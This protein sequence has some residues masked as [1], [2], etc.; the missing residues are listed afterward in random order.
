MVF[1]AA[2]ADCDFSGTKRNSVL[3]YDVEYSCFS[4]MKDI[5]YFWAQTLTDNKEI[6]TACIKNTTPLADNTIIRTLQ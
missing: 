3:A 5:K 4:K 6:D 1:L 2:A